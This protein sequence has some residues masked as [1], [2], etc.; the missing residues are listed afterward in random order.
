MDHVRKACV[1]PCPNLIMSHK[2]MQNHVISEAK[3]HI[4]SVARRNSLLAG[5]FFVVI[6]TKHENDLEL[7]WH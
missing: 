5:G 2:R 4:W 3:R 1:T 7:N 6:L